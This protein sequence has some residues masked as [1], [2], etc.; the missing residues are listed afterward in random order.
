MP[1]AA[2]RTP[3]VETVPGGY[4]TFNVSK[5]LGL[6][7]NAAT[8]FN[9]NRP[10]RARHR[11]RPS[12]ESLRRPVCSRSSSAIRLPYRAPINLTFSAT[13]NGGQFDFCR[14]AACRQA[15]AVIRCVA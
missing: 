7:G 6:Y 13:L 1:A 15:V 9:P 14:A 2:I 3:A 5:W 11:F 4:A 8:I 12:L 10:C